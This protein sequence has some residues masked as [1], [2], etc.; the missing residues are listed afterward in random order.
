MV[1]FSAGVEAMYCVTAF[2]PASVPFC[3]RRV[4]RSIRRSLFR[5]RRMSCCAAV[6]KRATRT[7]EPGFRDCPTGAAVWFPSA[8][9]PIATPERRHTHAP[10]TMRTQSLV[11][12]CVG[13]S[14]SFSHHIISIVSSTVDT[15]TYRVA[16]TLDVCIFQNAHANAHNNAY[17]GGCH[18]SC[19]S[20]ASAAPKPLP[21]AAGHTMNVRARTHASLIV[22]PAAGDG[23]LGAALAALA[24]L[25][26]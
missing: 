14:S 21:L 8:A 25:A 26:W 12:A 9:G 11:H 13:A 20:A 17:V 4:S 24:Q 2:I 1:R 3:V 23:G 15:T 7:A 16:C 18:A 19:A 6:T 22:W 10:C 5:S